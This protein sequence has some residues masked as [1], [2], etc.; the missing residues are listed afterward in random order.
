MRLRTGKLIS[1]EL[2]RDGANSNRAPDQVERE[3]EE[4]ASA[5]GTVT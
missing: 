5:D 2:N 1:P 4:K 3:T